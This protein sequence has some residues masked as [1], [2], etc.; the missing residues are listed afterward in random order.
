MLNYPARFQKERDGYVVTFR[1][2][3]EALTSGA[4]KKEA[5]AMATDALATAMEFYFEDRRQV[6]MPT[7]ARKEEELVE[8]PASV[9]VKVLL[10]N[11]MLKENMTPS[12][13]AKKLDTSPQTITRIVDLHHAT[14]IDTLADAFKAM[15]KTLNFSVA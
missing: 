5:M 15:G 11:E 9:A 7:K 4:T 3:P 1:D 14:K 12:R 8:I 13:L 10:L 2:I 6:P